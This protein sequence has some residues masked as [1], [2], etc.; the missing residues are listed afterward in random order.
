M[1]IKVILTQKNMEQ[2]QQKSASDLE[3]LNYF[4][5]EKRAER[6]L[7]DRLQLEE[8]MYKQ[9]SILGSSY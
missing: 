8:R 4:D 6:E 9:R 1:D 5:D 3:D 2:C 7:D